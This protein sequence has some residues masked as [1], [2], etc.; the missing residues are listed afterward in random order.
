VAEKILTRN[1]LT[2]L[3]ETGAVLSVSL[4]DF[5]YVVF[6]ILRFTAATSSLLS[7]CFGAYHGINLWMQLKT[8]IL[9]HC[10]NCLDP[11]TTSAG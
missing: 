8:G 5:S 4:F 1:F 11:L 2:R 10:D 9:R 6:T 3:Q 7:R